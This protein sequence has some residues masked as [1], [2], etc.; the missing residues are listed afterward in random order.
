MGAAGFELFSTSVYRCFGQDYSFMYRDVHEFRTA[1]PWTPKACPSKKEKAGSL[2]YQVWAPL[3]LGKLSSD[4]VAFLSKTHKY[5]HVSV[6]DCLCIILTIS[7][8]YWTQQ[9]AGYLKI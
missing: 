8:R 7:A 1:L 6:D 2:F 3:F 5:I 4:L 9:W